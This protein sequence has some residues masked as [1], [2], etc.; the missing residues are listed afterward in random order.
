MAQQKEAVDELYQRVGVVENMI[1]CARMESTE[2]KEAA[3]PR[4]RRLDGLSADTLEEDHLLDK[5]V[6]TEED[7]SMKEAFS[8]RV[9]RAQDG[10]WERMEPKP[11]PA[12]PRQLDAL[13]ADTLQEVTG[14]QHEEEMDA[15]NEKARA[16]LGRVTQRVDFWEKRASGLASAARTE[17]KPALTCSSCSPSSAGHPHRI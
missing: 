12:S 6:A 11:A 8:H 4:S 15:L 17:P 3:S 2:S 13:S 9:R 5:E 14:G 1:S 10:T 7:T 16:L